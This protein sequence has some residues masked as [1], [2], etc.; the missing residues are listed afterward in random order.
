MSTLKSAVR[1]QKSFEFR[2]EDSGGLP[3]RKT[4]AVGHRSRILLLLGCCMALSGCVS[5]AQKQTDSREVRF[6]QKTGPE[7]AWDVLEVFTDGDFE[8]NL[9]KA[10]DN[11]F[12]FYG[13]V[14]DEN[15]EPLADVPILVTAFDHVLDPFMFP[16]IGWTDI[17]N[18]KT[19]EDGRFEIK[20]R[21]AAA[22]V[23][24][25]DEDGYWEEETG[26]RGYAYAEELLSENEYPLPT[27][28][29]PAVFRLTPKPADAILNPVS[30]GAVRISPNGGPIY[31]ELDDYSGYSLPM[32]Q[33]SMRVFLTKGE[34]NSEGKYDWSCR[35]EVPGGGVQPRTQ[36]FIK[37]APEDGYAPF[38][39]FGY[40][41]DDPNWDHREEFRL[42]VRTK[43]GLY[44]YFELRART[45]HDPFISAWGVFNPTGARYGD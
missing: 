44:A 17:E 9:K 38:I 13:S 34:P 30:T 4:R 1:D 18:V 41:A 22:I 27:K 12:T 7:G 37:Q 14:I 5:T 43:D 25:V 36:L 29:E 15:G 32:G 26:F 8:E 40:E 35:F 33:G 6:L 10:V 28:D 23:V 39:E 19:G 20:N 16:F 42:F 31:L 3:F 45:K 21:K 11:E 24:D 2:T